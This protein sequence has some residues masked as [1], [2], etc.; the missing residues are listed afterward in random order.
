MERLPIHSS[1]VNEYSRAGWLF[2]KISDI[3][4]TFPC[5]LERGPRERPMASFFSTNLLALNAADLDRSLVLPIA[6]RLLNQ[7]F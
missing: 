2:V 5:T 7:F 6:Q 4:Y 1:H 3:V